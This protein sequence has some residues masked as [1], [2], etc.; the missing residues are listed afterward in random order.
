ME[1]NNSQAVSFFEGEGERGRG[2]VE[3]WRE[4]KKRKKREKKEKKRKEKKERHSV[5]DYNKAH[6][7]KEWGQNL[8]HIGRRFDQLD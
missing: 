8:D 5:G 1:S 6:C 4:K 3:R 7:S 2:E